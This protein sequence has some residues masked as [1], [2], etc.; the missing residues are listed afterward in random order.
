MSR[1]ICFITK[2]DQERYKEYQRFP[3]SEPWT[4]YDKIEWWMNE[5]NILKGGSPLLEIIRLSKFYPDFSI[6]AL[7]IFLGIKDTSLLKAMLLKTNN[8]TGAS[9]LYK[10]ARLGNPYLIKELLNTAESLGILKEV[11]EVLDRAQENPLIGAIASGDLKTIKMLLEEGKKVNSNQLNQ[12]RFYRSQSPLNFARWVIERAR[13]FKDLTE[14]GRNATRGFSPLG[15][16]EGDEEKYQ[17]IV[18]LLQKYQSV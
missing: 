17:E 12:G 3:T 5:S 14:E 1:I 18:S 9:P 15:S 10:A 11:L 2:I 6:Q 8:I 7:K 4:E 16:D 13:M